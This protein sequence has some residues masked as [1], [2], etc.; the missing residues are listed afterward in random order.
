M[1]KKIIL[2]TFCFLVSAQGN[3]FVLLSKTKRALPVTPL[4]PQIAF[5]WDG[6][7]PSIKEKN[8][9]AGGQY[10]NSTDEQI[11]QALLTQALGRWSNIRG[12]FVQL[13]LNTAQSSLAKRDEK[14]K[15]YSIVTESN[16]NVAVAAFANPVSIDDENYIEDCDIS[17]SNTSVTADSLNYTI[18]H[19]LGHCLGLGHPHTNYGAI[20]GYSRG[21]GEYVSLGA[22]DKAGVIYLYPD[23]AYSNGEKET[24]GCAA[25]GASTDL[26]KPNYFL[27][28]MLF[29][30]PIFLGR[31]TRRNKKV[32]IRLERRD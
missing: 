22:D 11:M 16:S 32:A 4:A 3:S 31:M 10:A 21:G 25:V 15:I 20:M 26:T 7:A 19:E 27:I 30:G 23:P 6:K 29:V 14:D 1:R 24:Y 28:A 9:F 17:I 2:S 18:T 5:V 12:S 8:K 13:T